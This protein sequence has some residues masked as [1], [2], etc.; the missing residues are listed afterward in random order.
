[1]G[2]ID[3]AGGDGFRKRAR[4]RLACASISND[5]HGQEIGIVWQWIGKSEEPEWAAYLPDMSTTRHA[6]EEFNREEIR[7]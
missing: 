3:G 2:R 7:T 4:F 1:M 5:D 6:N